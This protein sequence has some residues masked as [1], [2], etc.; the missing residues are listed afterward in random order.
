MENQYSKLN[1]GICMAGAVSA[2]AYTAGAMD[3]IIETLERWEREKIKIREKLTNDKELSDREK[4]IPLHD[5]EIKLLS[6]ASA[7]GMTAA[8]LS[9][10]FIDGTFL[11]KNKNSNDIISQNYNLPNENNIKSRFKTAYRT[12]LLVKIGLKPYSTRH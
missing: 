5:V 3:Y 7:G 4:A 9:Y 12:K 6:G 2:G 10:S 1:L 11:N 8:I